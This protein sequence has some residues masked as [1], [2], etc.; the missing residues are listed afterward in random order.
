MTNLKNAIGS[1]ADVVSEEIEH[2]RRVVI[3]GE[4][5]QKILQAHIKIDG[6]STQLTR[7]DND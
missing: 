3:S 5:E 7:L 2:I 4:V 1:L 6:L